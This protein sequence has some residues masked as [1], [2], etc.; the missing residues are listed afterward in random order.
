MRGTKAD[1]ERALREALTKIDHGVDVAPEKITISEWLPRWL[2]RHKAAGHIG[3]STYTAYESA[4]RVHLVSALGRLR[5]SELRSDHIEDLK[6]R[7]LSGAASTAEHPLGASTVHQN[8]VVLRQAL[9]QALMG[10]LIARN[11]VD[12]VRSPSTKRKREKRALTS[13]EIE[14]L[15]S[16]T[17]GTVVDVPVRFTLATGVRQGELLAFAWSDLDLDD[18]ILRV[19]RNARY[20][21]GRGVVSSTPK[22]PRSRRAIELS[23]TTA[24]LLREHRLSQAERRLS[25]GPAWADANLIFPSS[26]GTLWIAPNFYRAYREALE[27]S[28]ISDPDSVDSHTLRHTAATQWIKAGIDIFTVSRRLGHASAAFTMDVYGHLVR[29]QQADAAAALD[30]LIARN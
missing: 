24:R 4:M 30:H 6:A 18:H 2:D 21:V 8:L 27:R 14:S 22:T 3:D 20:F 19:R 28:S 12:A 7:W 11:P 5:L 26:V 16:A 10:G 1:A 29:G 17:T 25:L 15:L 9:K 13:D 23:P